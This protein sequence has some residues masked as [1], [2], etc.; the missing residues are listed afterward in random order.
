MYK[1]YF[2]RIKRIFTYKAY[3][4]IIPLRGRGLGGGASLI[5]LRGR[6]LG[7]GAKRRLDTDYLRQFRY[8]L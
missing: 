6:G 4:K 5:P 2:S 3:F 1:A 7:G 8:D